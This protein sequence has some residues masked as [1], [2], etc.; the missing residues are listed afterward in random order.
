LHQ[1][2]RVTVDDVLE[3]LASGMSEAEVLAD[4]PYLTCE[5]IEAC[6]AFD[7]DRK[8]RVVSLSDP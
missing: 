4:F 3:Y 2:H 6:R 1:G 7:A 5:D 8:L